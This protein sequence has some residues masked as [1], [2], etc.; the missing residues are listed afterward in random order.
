LGED[1]RLS[2]DAKTAL[3]KATSIRTI[4]DLLKDVALTDSD[5]TLLDEINARIGKAAANWNSVLSWEVYQWLTD[6]IPKFVYFGEYEIL[7]SKIN[8]NELADRAK[9]GT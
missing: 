3:K 9:R 1:T 8:L 7:P 6:R 5:K 2:S 4:P